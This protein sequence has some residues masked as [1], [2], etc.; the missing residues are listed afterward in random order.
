MRTTIHIPDEDYEYI[1]KLS[2][3]LTV[4]LKKQISVSKIITMIIKLLKY[5][6]QDKELDD[7][8]KIL[9]EVAKKVM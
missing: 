2:G 5:L 4:E 8:L 3:F 6:A 7:E 1:M 9:L